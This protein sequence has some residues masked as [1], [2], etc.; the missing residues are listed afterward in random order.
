[1]AVGVRCVGCS[2]FRRGSGEF[3]PFR[4][5][6][7]RE[8]SPLL[9][10]RARSKLRLETANILACYELLHRTANGHLMNIRH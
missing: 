3:P 1:M 4:L 9:G 5:E 2:H 6:Q 8:C 10:I 7:L